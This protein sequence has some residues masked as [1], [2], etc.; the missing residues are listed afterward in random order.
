VLT[1]E[2]LR[3]RRAGGQLVPRFLDAKARRR[4]LP[5]AEELIGMVAG[6]RGRRR[7]EV[8]AALG[9]VEHPPRDRMVVQG[10]EKLVL[11]RCSFAV[12]GRVEP[13]LVREEVF[14]RAAAARR[15]LGP[16]EAFDRPAV[17]ESAA[18]A[19]RSLVSTPRG[20]HGADELEE[21][22]FADLRNNERLVDIPAVTPRALL[23]RYDV[24]LA[25][26]VL[27]R[28]TRVSIALEGESPARVRELFR[29][30]RFHGLLHRV[31]RVDEGRYLIELDGPFSLFSAVQKYGIKLALFLPAVLRCERWRLRAELLWGKRHEPLTF[32]LGT[33]HGLATD[34][35]PPTGVAPHLAEF[36]ERFEALESPWKVARNER[37]FA[38]PG[39]VVCVPD[40]VFTS[41]ETGEEVFL[42]AFGFWS[43]AAVWQRIETLANGFPSRIILAVGK[44]LRVSEEALES[45]E[46]ELYVYAGSMKP[47]AVLER[48]ERAG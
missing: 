1:S 24:A 29:A 44:Q 19:L 16:G 4:L 33:E 37:I 38:L 36:V 40:L 43:R 42:E 5:V 12:D 21:L 15:A 41:S 31:R 46:G 6:L 35:R 25:Q 48:L 45:D 18:L 32:E 11:D 2:H 27:L 10:L 47:R 17:M 7:E 39:E 9:S 22:L 3:V 13:S 20:A 30:A 8:E 23:E 34:E 14:R 26:G 28:A